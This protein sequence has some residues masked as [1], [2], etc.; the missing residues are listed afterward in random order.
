M[1]DDLVTWLRALL[2]EDERDARAVEGDGVWDVPSTGVVQ[3][4]GVGDLD[5]LVMAP[6]NVAHHMATHDPARVL[7]DVDAKRHILDAHPLEGPSK[8]VPFQYCGTCQDGDGIVT[9]PAPCPTQRAL[10]LP[11]ADRPGYR[12]E[13]KP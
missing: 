1:A 7:A 3:L 2:D 9:A 12:D 13:W 11:Y 4:G 8:Y 5:G 10:A 6:R